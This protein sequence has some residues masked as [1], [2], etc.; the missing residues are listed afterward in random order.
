M[1]GCTGLALVSSAAIPPGALR[2]RA[3][4]AGWLFA[5]TPA[6]AQVD[7][8]AFLKKDSFTSIT[9]SPTGEYF[10]ATAPSD[11]RTGIA[12]IRRSDMQVSAGMN[13]GKNRHV[14]ELRWISPDRILFDIG[15]KFG[16]LDQPQL[17]GELFSLYA[18]SGQTELLVGQRVY[19]SSLDGRVKKKKEE[20]IIA[21]VVD[22]LPGDD[23]AVIISA[24]PF[25][26]LPSRRAERMEVASGKRTIIVRAPVSNATFTT[27]SFGVVRLAIGYGSDNFYK[28]FYRSG[29]K[30]DWELIND[31]SV[32]GRIESPLG[33]SADS[34][35]AYLQADHA[36]G[37]DSIV[38][39]DVA[40][41]ARKEI[42]RD[43]KGDP[44]SIV[45]SF[46]AAATP[47]GA[48]FKD[49]ITRTMFF[50][51]AS[52]EARL[53]R[54]LEAAF[55]GQTVEITSTTKDGKLAVVSTSSAG[56]PGEFYLF[57]TVAK[58]AKHIFSRRREID[59]A[60]TA[61]VRPVD[62]QARDGW[63]L[64]GYLTVPKGSSGKNLP[65]VV[66]PHGGPFGIFE[67]WTFDE[68]AQ[69]LAKAGYAVL[70]I[71]FR[72][73]SNFGRAFAQA[74]AR[75]WGGKM[76][77][78]LTDATRWVIAQG[79]TDAKRICIYG[80]SYGGY[81]ALMGV[82]KE[83]ELYQC[84]V[85]YVGVYDLDM[86]VAD[87]RTNSRSS[88]TWLKEWVGEGAMLKAKS[89]T[90]LAGQVKVPVLLVAGEEDET[91]P[92]AQSR[93]M[94]MALRKAGVPVETLYV[95][96]EGHG[97]YVEANR[98]EYY[99]KLLDFLARYLGGMR[100]K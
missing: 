48:V 12:I 16:M 67:S 62:V 76:Q 26:P 78:D 80:A 99:V 66:M 19:A 90:N 79:I 77:D 35:T 30:G 40:T 37:P 27:D 74:G 20:Q 22:D 24:S 17:T 11:D 60:T 55:S 8:D 29:D 9:I 64:H 46:D 32:T 52:P 23:Q 63:A 71:N 41:K 38:A 88:A 50:D 84:A 96:H 44:A 58:T 95:A 42:L 87:K 39:F 25:G 3:L 1:S 100:S 97:F 89:A 5:A 65:T 36:E 75:E 61:E 49:G 72:G 45:H 4:L 47:V 33:F 43:G 70:Q 51:K 34:K 81:A 93:K 59:P 2:L 10:A 21:T 13:P 86:L 69:L 54:S 82:A 92:I 85:G 31:E 91:A 94:E 83:P 56:D 98:R 14:H 68:D 73:S 18:K 7:V 28:L 6:V 15:E 53:Q 57:D